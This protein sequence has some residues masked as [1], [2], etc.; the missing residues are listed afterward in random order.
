MYIIGPTQL[1]ITFLVILRFQGFVLYTV[2]FFI[3][4]REPTRTSMAR[5]VNRTEEYS[6]MGT[7]INPGGS[8]SRDYQ[9]LF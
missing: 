9:P 7:L 2:A 5:V 8:A 1:E 4:C 3:L 6:I